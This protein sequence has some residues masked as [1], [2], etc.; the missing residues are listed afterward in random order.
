[1]HPLSKIQNRL[2][3]ATIKYLPSYLWVKCCTLE[4]G[5]QAERE[6]SKIRTTRAATVWSQLS[7]AEARADPR[8]DTN[9]LEPPM[10]IGANGGACQPS[11]DTYGTSCL[12]RGQKGY[13]ESFSAELQPMSA[14]EFNGR[15]SSHTEDTTNLRL[16]L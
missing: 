1:M 2:K 14:E 4:S 8:G 15:N 6:Q 11:R 10:Q 13:K 16:K 5:D 3:E 9:L 7:V 12:C